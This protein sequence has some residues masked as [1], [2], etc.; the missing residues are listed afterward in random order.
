MHQSVARHPGYLPGDPQ[1]RKLSVAL[2]A[3]GLAT[4][5]LLYSTQPLLPELVDAFQVSPDQS[6]FSVSFATFGLGLALLVAGPAS[7]VLGRTNLMRWSVAATSIFALASAFAPTWH[8]LLALRGLQGIAMAGLPAVAMAYLRE[9]VHQDSH[10]RASGLYIAGTAVGGMAGRLIAG[11][12]SDLGG[13]RVATGG[14]AVVGVLCAAIVWLL[15]PASRNFQPNAARPHDLLRVLKDPALLALYGI[16]ATAVGAFVA[17]YNGA[18]FRLSSTPYHLSAGAAG[19]V[20]CVYLLGSAGSAT[21]GTLADRYGRRTVVPIGCLITLAGVAITL[22]APL[23]LIVLGLAVMTAGFFAVHGVASGWVPA[24]AHASGVGTG[25]A[26]SMYL[27][28]FYLGSSVFGGLAGTAWSRA[29]WIGVA[30]EAGVLFLVTLVL[31]VLLRNVPS[32]VRN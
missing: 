9:E 12:L 5:A 16:A 25:Q 3:A 2:F 14:I 20:F 24:R 18:V 19:L 11:G 17:V 23:P 7:E 21:A 29:D 31:A 30:G 10:A 26:S 8:L 32:R 22:A 4:F 13:W 28:A 27:F 1:Y 15:L 6:A